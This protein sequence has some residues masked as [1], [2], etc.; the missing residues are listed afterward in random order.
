M[1]TGFLDKGEVCHENRF[2]PTYKGWKRVVEFLENLI[3]WGFDPTYKGWKPLIV[4]TDVDREYFA[5]ILPTR[6]GN[7][8]PIG[9]R[10]D[11]DDALILPTRDGNRL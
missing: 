7:Q 11:V 2:D 10:V 5:L 4:N 9:Y 6:D 8:F 1:E 3:P